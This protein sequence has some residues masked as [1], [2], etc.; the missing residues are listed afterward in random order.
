MPD[1]SGTPSVEAGHGEL[2]TVRRLPVRQQDPVP[3]GEVVEGEIISEEE[4]RRLTS[5]RELARARWQGYRSDAVTVVRVA[6]RVAGL[7]VDQLPARWR[8]PEHLA[9]VRAHLARQ[10]VTLPFRYPGAVA[11]GS[12]SGVRAWW[13]WVSVRDLYEASQATAQLVARYDDIHRYRVRRRWWTL[14]TLVVVGGGLLVAELIEGPLVWWLAGLGV[15]VPLAIAGRRRQDKGRQAIMRPRSLSW[16]MDGG[17]HMV[18]AF[19]EAK[20]IGKDEGL[21]FIT[22]PKR[23]GDGWLVVVDLPASRKASTVIARREDLASALAVDEMQLITERVRGKGGHAG[24]LSLWVADDDPYATAP[25][26]SPLAEA[27]SWDLW[28]P[29]PLGM[30]ARGQRITLPVVWTS[31]LVGA[32]PRMGK[33]YVARIPATAGALD[34]YVRMIVADGKGGKDWRPFAVVAHRYIP[35]AREDSNRR[36]IAVLAEAAGDV[37]DRFGRLAEMDDDLC[38]ESKVT[39]ELSRNPEH[40][41]PLTMILIDEVQNYLEDDTKLD[42]NNP[43]SKKTVGQRILE[44]LT[45]IAK[46]GP[47]AGFM[48]VLATQKPDGQV[49]PDKLRGQIG[50]RFALKVMT[51]QASETILGA[52]TYKAGMDASKLLKS[53]KGVGLLLGADGETELD[54]GEAITVKTD[55]LVIKAIRAACERG[56]AARVAAGTLTGDAAGDTELGELSPEVAARIEAEAARAEHA[57]PAP[58]ADVVELVDE[59]QADTMP[60]VLAQLVGVVDVDETGVVATA[61]LA[62]RI[63]WDAKALGEALRSAQVERPTPDKQRVPG[64]KPYPVPV[65][66]LDAIRAAIVR[67]G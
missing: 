17:E 20:L 51:W 22:G 27:E 65:Q 33:T 30:T 36:L 46:T 37:D 41:M 23:D 43:K 7:A 45:F 6:S 38:P 60:E 32:I 63:G 21:A 66:S 2:A 14:V 12:V 62:G 8:D 19:R 58:A 53:H 10:A 67:H 48:L 52:G 42:P 28:R 55:M 29:V 44:L 61:E 9:Q 49:L 40:D 25:T 5:Q 3:T 1:Q 26:V 50:T 59:D 64:G 16:S 57:T 56:R 54:A 24:R 47:A 4:Y 39:P 31:L 15:S 34:P 11:R 13:A 18:T 35:N